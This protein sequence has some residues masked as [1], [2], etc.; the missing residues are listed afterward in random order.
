[1]FQVSF[2]SF[3]MFLPIFR[4]FRFN[5]DAQSYAPIAAIDELPANYYDAPPEEPKGPFLCDDKLLVFRHLSC[6][7]VL[8]PYFLSF[9]VFIAGGISVKLLVASFQSA[10]TNLLLRE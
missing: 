5:P 4:H 1:M 2:P 10:P 7:N 8:F 9:N 6:Q 3:L